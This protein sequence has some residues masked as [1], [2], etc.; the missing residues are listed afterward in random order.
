MLLNR[1]TLYLYNI[2]YTGS[3]QQIKLN[4]FIYVVYY[5][6][7]YIIHAYVPSYKIFVRNTYT[8]ICVYI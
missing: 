7:Y 4:I 8:N 2:K 1:F 6:I 5:S 3:D